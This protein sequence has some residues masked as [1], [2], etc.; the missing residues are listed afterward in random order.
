[1]ETACLSDMEIVLGQTAIDEKTNE[2]TAIPEILK[3]LAIKECT[4]TIDAI[5][6]LEKRQRCAWSFEHAL[7]AA[8]GYALDLPAIS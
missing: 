7:S 1:M 5:L 3:M 6:L 2:I 8:S 4:V